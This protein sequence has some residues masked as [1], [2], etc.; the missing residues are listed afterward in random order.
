MHNL[1]AAPDSFEANSQ[2]SATTAAAAALDFREVDPPNFAE[3]VAPDFDAE[4]L[5]NFAEVE[6]EENGDVSG[7]ANFVRTSR[8]DW[9][10]HCWK[11]ARFEELFLVVAAVVVVVAVVVVAAVVVV[12]ASAAAVVVVGVAAAAAARVGVDGAAAPSK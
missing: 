5:P 6:G 10:N 11:S 7:V 8:D 3:I 12:V 4:Y 2:D 9:E 1:P